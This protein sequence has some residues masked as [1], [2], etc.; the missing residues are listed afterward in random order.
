MA[1]AAKEV[2]MR[3]VGEHTAYGGDNDPA[4]AGNPLHHL[5]DCRWVLLVVTVPKEHVVAHCDVK[6]D[7][8]GR[9]GTAVLFAH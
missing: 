4:G 2:A 1:L 3:S 8:A 9:G 5:L 7:V 6:T